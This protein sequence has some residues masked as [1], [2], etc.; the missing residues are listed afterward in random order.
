VSN[1]APYP[2]FLSLVMVVRN[3]AMSLAAQL[4]ALTQQLAGLVA[5]YEIIV[6]DNGSNDESIATLKALTAHSGLPNLQVFAL[7]KE[8]DADTASW[9]GMENALG[10]FVATI[11]LATDDAAQL[12][13][14]LELAVQGTDVVFAHNTHATKKGLVYHTVAGLFHQ[15][16]WLLFR[17]HLAHEAPHYRLLSKRVVNFILQHPMPSV[18]YRHLPATAGFAKATLDYA[19]TPRVMPRKHLGESISRYCAAAPAP[20]PARFQ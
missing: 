15:A 6:V 18:S 7:T 19:A 16:Y 5:E 10:D 2:I 12:P 8:V 13:A 20:P 9:A 14:M 11:N 17:V 3:Q 1:T 4:S